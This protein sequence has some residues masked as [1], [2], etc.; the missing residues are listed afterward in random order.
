[1]SINWDL[2]SDK[3]RSWEK[4]P[5]Y[6]LKIDLKWQH[7]N[8]SAGGIHSQGQTCMLFYFCLSA[9]CMKCHIAT[10]WNN[11]YEVWRMTSLKLSPFVAFNSTLAVEGTKTELP[12]SPPKPSKALTTNC[13]R[14][15]HHWG[16]VSLLP[17][18]GPF[19]EDFI[20]SVLREINGRCLGENDWLSPTPICQQNHWF[21]ELGGLLSRLAK[22][23]HLFS[24][25]QV[26]RAWGWKETQTLF[27]SR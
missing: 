3:E 14:A 13:R 5:C 22:V 12:A 21:P 25:A 26:Y 20:L 1:M 15:A 2:C 7:R 24:W 27:A 17:G 6:V 9:T 11:T 8:L 10:G 18:R 16:W 19:L 4:R 23:R